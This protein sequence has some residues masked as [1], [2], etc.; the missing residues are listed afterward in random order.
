MWQLHIGGSIIEGSWWYVILIFPAGIVIRLFLSWLREFELR[1][2]ATYD[3]DAGQKPRPPTL[4]KEF[5][6][7]WLQ[8]FCSTHRS[9][10]VRDYWLPAI[11]GW[12]ELA[13]YPYF[14][15]T[16]D[17]KPIGGWIA[18]KTVAQWGAWTK[19][20][21]NYQRFLIGNALVIAASVLLATQLNIHPVQTSKINAS[22]ISQQR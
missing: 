3:F 13:A 19:S 10:Q 20:R 22:A 12:L 18:L 9:A 7:S 17:W 1:W 5:W 6:R 16:G 11:V 4:P 15:A 2:P 8:A 14:L 21:S